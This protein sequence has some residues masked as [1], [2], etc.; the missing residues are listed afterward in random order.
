MQ[1]QSCHRNV[2]TGILN[3][4]HPQRP[5]CCTHAAGPWPS[6]ATVLESFA[7]LHHACAYTCVPVRQQLFIVW[8]HVH[9]LWTCATLFNSA[10]CAAL[11]LQLGMWCFWP[12]LFWT[13]CCTHCLCASPCA[14]LLCS[15]HALHDDD[16]H[17]VLALPCRVCGL[18]TLSYSILLDTPCSC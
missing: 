8:I 10:P 7:T 5:C 6:G 18:G 9:S 2:N 14:T 12:P 17:F 3:A 13:M 1:W 4:G 11:P 15:L 16:R